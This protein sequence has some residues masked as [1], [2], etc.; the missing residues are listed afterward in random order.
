MN[1]A[2]FGREAVPMVASQLNIRPVFDV[3]ADVQGRDLYSAAQDID[4]VIKA[5]RPMLEGADGDLERTGRDDAR[6]LYRTVHRHRAGHRSG[7]PVSGD[8]LPKLDRS[9]D[10]ADG[11]AVR[12]GGVLWMLF[13]SQTPMSVPAL[14]GTLMCI[15]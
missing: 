10:R 12:A 14:M 11:G 7:V 3:H 5:N 1:L 8:E 15:G 9:A 13:L 2:S 6:E 4:K